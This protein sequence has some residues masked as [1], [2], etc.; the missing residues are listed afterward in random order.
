MISII[1]PTYQRAHVFGRS[2]DSIRNQRFQDWELLIVDDGSTDGTEVLVREWAE[3]DKR[4]KFLK[5]P[6]TRAKG[7]SACRNIGIEHAKGEFLAFLDSDDEWLPKR[8]NSALD[9]MEQNQA[10]AI[11]SGALVKG[12]KTDYMRTSRPLKPNESVFDF[13]LNSAT[14]TQTSTL[15][16]HRDIAEQVSF[17]ENMTHHEDYDFFIQVSKITRWKYFE[18]F[19]IV[20]HWEENSNRKINY[21]NCLD[22]YLNYKSESLDKEVRIKYLSYMSE[23]LVKRGGERK[24]LRE[25]QKLLK[26]EESD[27]SFR[28]RLLFFSPQLFRLFLKFR[29]A[30]KN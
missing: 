5:R 21:R 2:I 22:F 26:Q 10:K 18:N 7:P 17:V 30:V 29:N 24:Y 19:D 13:I 25:Y 12:K 4:I 20:V 16:I 1:V 15:I 6:T 27:F 8:L 9:Y 14:F 28:K 23:D 3:K 11:Y